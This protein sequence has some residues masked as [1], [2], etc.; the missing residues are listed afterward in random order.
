MR[1]VYV[2]GPFRGNTTWEI[3]CNVRRAE[4]YALS[5]WRLGAVALCPHANT[6]FFHKSAPD[7]IWLEGT[8]ELLRR[9]DA[10]FVIPNSE[11]SQGTRCEIT[12]AE[13]LGLPVFG[14]LG[15]LGLWIRGVVPQ[16]FKG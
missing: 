16:G 10:V 6:R 13:R 15:H 4:E 12:E 8:L 1:V 2:A 9:C 14:D 11:K 7:E 3:E 5:I